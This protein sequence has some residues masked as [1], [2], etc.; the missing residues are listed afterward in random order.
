M[1]IITSFQSS[2]SFLDKSNSST[3]S[4]MVAKSF[5]FPMWFIPSPLI[6]KLIETFIFPL[7]FPFKFFCSK[8]FV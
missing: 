5:R 8:I 1:N 3:L 2:I 4:Q 6:T 7:S